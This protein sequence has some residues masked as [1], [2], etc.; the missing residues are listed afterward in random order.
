MPIEC[1]MKTKCLSL[2]LIMMGCLQMAA[3]LLN[4]PRLKALALMSH[5]SVCPKVFTSQN[6]YETFSAQFWIEYV[7]DQGKDHQVEITPS[8]IQKL[9]GPYNR[10]NLYGAALSYAPVLS[11]S[12]KTFS[13]WKSVMDYGF[14]TQDG[15]LNE[16]GIHADL[17]KGPIQIHIVPRIEYPLNDNWTLDYE[18]HCDELT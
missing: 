11:S 5:A 1:S 16:L 18:V 17:K 10:R 13:M 6:G 12:P 14:C 7:D 4:W 9:K 15:I 3:D 2:I 8:R